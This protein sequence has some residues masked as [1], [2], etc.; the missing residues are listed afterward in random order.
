M[1]QV[2]QLWLP[3]DLVVE[4]GGLAVLVSGRE[5]EGCDHLRRVLIQDQPFV[6]DDGGGKSVLWKG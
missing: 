1:L 4:L 5:L 3:S 6:S 2:P